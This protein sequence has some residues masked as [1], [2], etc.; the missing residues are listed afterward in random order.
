MSNKIAPQKHVVDPLALIIKL[1]ESIK[2]LPA[3]SEQIKSAKALIQLL[4][5]KELASTWSCSEVFIRKL[6]T[7]GEG[8]KVTHLGSAIRIRYIDALAYLESQR[9]A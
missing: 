6:L 9:S 3:D 4:T 8:P 7:R 1:T 2:E 5:I